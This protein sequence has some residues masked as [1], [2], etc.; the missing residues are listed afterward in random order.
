[1]KFTLDE[2]G[3]LVSL[4]LAGA[5]PEVLTYLPAPAG[6][7]P[8][9]SITLPDA[10]LQTYAQTYVREGAGPGPKEVTLTAEADALWV[11]IEGERHKFLPLSPVEF[12]DEQYDEVRLKFT[13][14][15]E[16]RPTA[17]EVAGAA[18]EVIKFVVK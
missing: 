1:M 2:Q 12:Y 13:L 8:L 17:V 9:P 16:G 7:A 4:S 15:A 6:V 3:Q 10:T 14:D 5:S 18:P 11:E